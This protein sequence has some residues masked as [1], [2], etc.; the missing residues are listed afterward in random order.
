MAVVKVKVTCGGVKRRFA[1]TSYEH[2]HKTVDSLSGERCNLRCP[3]GEPIDSQEALDRASAG[4]K[5]TDAL[6]IEAT[7]LGL[8]LAT[9]PAAPRPT[10][11]TRKEKLAWMEQ[12]LGHSP[13]ELLATTPATITAAP[14]R[15]HH[16]PAAAARAPPRPAE[17]WDS[18]TSEDD[19]EE[20]CL[21]GAAGGRGAR[22]TALPVRTLPQKVAAYQ[23]RRREC[24][25]QGGSPAEAGSRVVPDTTTTTTTTAMRVGVKGGGVADALDQAAASAQKKQQPEEAAPEADTDDDSED[26]E[27]EEEEDEEDDYDDRYFEEGPH[28]MCPP[29]GGSDPQ[30]HHL[31]HGGVGWE[32]ETL[33][34]LGVGGY[35]PEGPLDYDDDEDDVDDDSSTDG[36]EEAFIE[37][38]SPT[39]CGYLHSEDGCEPPVG[40][41]LVHLLLQ[42]NASLRRQLDEAAGGRGSRRGSWCRHRPV[43]S[44]SQPPRSR[45]S[46]LLSVTVSL[47]PSVSSR[48]IPSHAQSARSVRSVRSISSQNPYEEMSMAAYL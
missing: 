1:A 41:A 35:Y 24:R 39:G 33:Q 34:E 28:A 37:G 47:P 14:P 7:K 40:P 31:L 42:E 22:R 27:E 43:R 26:E 8:P 30:P 13:E 21:A 48:S 29:T 4:L 5:P 10:S 3:S 23:Q 6:A 17:V 44:L 18:D 19:T 11:P 2:L 38:P 45:P 46:D 16:H 32:A 25:Q 9:P 20:D 12:Q 36:S 15:Q